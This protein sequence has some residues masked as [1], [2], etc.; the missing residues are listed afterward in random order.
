MPTTTEP[1]RTLHVSCFTPTFLPARLIAPHPSYV[2]RYQTQAF[3][4]C[5]PKNS[6]AYIETRSPAVVSYVLGRDWRTQ[7]YSKS[8]GVLHYNGTNIEWSEQVAEDFAMRIL[9]AGGAVVDTTHYRNDE[10][11]MK[12]AAQFARFSRM[13]EHIFGCPD[14]GG[15]WV[16]NLDGRVPHEYWKACRVAWDGDSI[17][18][19]D[20][21]EAM[22]RETEMTGSP[23]V[24][25]DAFDTSTLNNAE[26]MN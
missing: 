3:P 24:P 18:D 17:L 26:T 19:A 14:D 7:L 13:K 1:T 15:L 22:I 23:P 21:I 2:P 11:Y 6:V 5:R 4:T 9:R 16:L 10:F 25:N 8:S 20:L 12:R